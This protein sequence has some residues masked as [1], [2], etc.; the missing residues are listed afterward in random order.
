MRNGKPWIMVGKHLRWFRFSRDVWIDDV[1]IGHWQ[2][3]WFWQ[4]FKA[5]LF[6]RED[7]YQ[8]VVEEVDVATHQDCYGISISKPN[9]VRVGSVDAVV[10]VGGNDEVLATYEEISESAIMGFFASVLFVNAT[11]IRHGSVA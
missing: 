7:V 6:T 4:D 1:N 10:R 5:K 11:L 2:P 8:S 3:G 9:G